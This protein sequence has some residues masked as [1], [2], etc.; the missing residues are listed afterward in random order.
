VELDYQEEHLTAEIKQNSNYNK[1]LRIQGFP[2]ILQI[3]TKEDK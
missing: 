1:S 3:A 2:T